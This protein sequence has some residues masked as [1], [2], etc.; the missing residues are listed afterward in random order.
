MVCGSLLLADPTSSSCQSVN[1]W[2]LEGGDLWGSTILRRPI[3]KVIWTKSISMYS[4][5]PSL[6]FPNFDQVEHIKL[7]WESNAL[8]SLVFTNI[9]VFNLSPLCL[10]CPTK[11]VQVDKSSSSYKQHHKQN[12][13]RAILAA[14]ILLK[15]LESP[16]FNKSDPDPRVSSEYC[17][18]LLYATSLGWNLPLGFSDPLRFTSYPI[19]GRYLRAFARPQSRLSL[20]SSWSIGTN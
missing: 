18:L 15:P 8:Q 1:I 19:A 10:F 16:I 2:L 14:N 6:D 20:V 9:L 3:L 5:V 17:W 12:Q 4:L 7:G 13:Q 11:P